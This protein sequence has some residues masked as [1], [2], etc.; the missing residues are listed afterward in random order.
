MIELTR[1]AALGASAGLLLPRFAIAQSDTRPAITIAVQKVSTSGTLEPMREQSNVGSRTFSLFLEPLIDIDWTGDQRPLPR[2][3][4]SWRRIDE[5]TVELTLRDNV[6]FHDG[7]PMMAEDVAFAFGDARMWNGTLP[8]SQG[9][10]SSTTAGA[11]TKTPPPEAPAI[12]KATYPGFA[13]IQ[14][15]D[16]RTVRYVNSTPDLTI[17][18]RLTRITGSILSRKAFDA[19]PTWLDWARLPI[20][21]GPYRVARYRPDQDLLLEA[22]DDYWGG[23]PPLKSIRLIEVSDVATRVNG[24]KAGDFDFICDMPPDQIPVIEAAPKYHVVGGRINNI[25]LT[26][27]DTTHPVLANPFVRRAMSHAVDRQ[28]IVDA[29]WAGRTVVPKG[30]QWPFY[31]KMLIEDWNVPTFDPA[32]AKQLLRQGG[33]KG[34]EIPYQLLNNYYTNQVAGSQALVA[35]WADI[36]LNVRIEMKE[37]WGQILGKF[38]GRGI[39]DNSNSAWFNDPVASMSTYGPGGQTWEAGQWHNAEYA[40]LLAKLQTG[41]TLDER[42]AA[43]RRMLMIVEREDPSFI[44]LHQNATFTGKRRDIK[45]KAADS[46]A[47][48]F[49]QGNFERV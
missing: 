35:G 30:L 16:A 34:E 36:G 4:T 28:A 43:F 10:F 42:R 46:F 40:G 13:S 31:D 26:V 9:L 14:I 33:Y 45:W 11:A 39:C 23:R 32:L 41:T 21:T 3:A 19:A 5:K 20:G 1:R 38:P 12:A 24:L 27:M 18:G 37:N 15:V 25:R 29:L 2:L 8:S 22:F 6:R 47:M 48:D 49:R 44:V 7:Q 17:E